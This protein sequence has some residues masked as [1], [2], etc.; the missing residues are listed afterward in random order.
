M[1]SNDQLPTANR[2]SVSMQTRHP[3]PIARTDL[4][5]E[6]GGTAAQRCVPCA[7]SSGCHEKIDTLL[8]N[9]SLGQCRQ[10]FRLYDS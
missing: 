8:A 3:R 2:I 10:L 7:W 5:A 4:E 9:R 1:F 6:Q